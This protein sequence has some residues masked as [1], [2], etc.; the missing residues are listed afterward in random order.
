MNFGV[1]LFLRIPNV[2]SLSPLTSLRRVAGE[3]RNGKFEYY[4]STGCVSQL[5]D[6]GY[7]RDT[8]SAFVTIAD[9]D[10]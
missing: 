1:F 4:F 8:C 7:N 5:F 2:C 3:P 10:Q 9:A 6:I